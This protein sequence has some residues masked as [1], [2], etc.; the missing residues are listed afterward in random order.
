MNWT[1]GFFG[2][3]II[4]VYAYAC[5]GTTPAAF[6]EAVV[7]VNEFGAAATQ[8]TEPVSLLEAEV[9]RVTIS[10]IPAGNIRAGEKYNIS[11]NG[12][13]YTFE[14]TDVALPINGDADEDAFDIAQNLTNQINNDTTSPITGLFNA[15]ASAFI[16]GDI[17]NNGLLDD[18]GAFITITAQY[19]GNS[20]P[21]IPPG[22]PRGYGGDMDLVFSVTRAP[23]EGRAFGN[24]TGIEINETSARI[25]GDL[26]GAEPWCETT[27]LTPN[28]QYFSSASFYTDIRYAINSIVPGVGSVASPGVIDATTG[29]LNW[30][31]GFH[32]TFI[33]E[34]YATGCDGVENTSPGIHNVR[35]YPDLDPPTDITFDPLTLPNCPAQAGDTT[36]FNSSDFVT[37][38]WNNDSAGEID[39]VLV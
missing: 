12:V 25:C 28:T 32:G 9:E 20:A 5:D 18:V 13:R 8:P 33:V 11:L 4:R 23:G 24:M 29:E 35:I 31:A 19:D 37:W 36:D 34:S 1:D 26:T 2:D 16:P 6:R 27:A 21:P 3:A 10:P 39:S 7:T 14:T 30:N 17:N 22:V 38:S 15:T